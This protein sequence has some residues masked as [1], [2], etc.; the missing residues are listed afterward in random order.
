METKPVTISGYPLES[1]EAR[2]AVAVMLQERI[3]NMHKGCLTLINNSIPRPNRGD[4]PEGEDTICFGEFPDECNGHCLRLWTYPPGMTKAEA[5]IIWSKRQARIA[6]A[7][8][9]GITGPDIWLTP[10][11]RTAKRRNETT[12]AGR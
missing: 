1:L 7:K 5:R 2:A 8:K 9:Q 6:E 12:A 3:R 10:E 11:Q 4:R